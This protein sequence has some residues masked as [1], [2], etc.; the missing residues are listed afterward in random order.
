MTNLFQLSWKQ[1][2]FKPLS[3]LMNIILFA[4]G[5]GIVSLLLLISTEIEEK[6]DKNQAG[7]GMV[8][9]AKGSPLQLILCAIFHID[10]PTGNIKLK[11]TA[12]LKKHP[13]V[14]QII[15]QALGDSYQ[16]FRIVGTNH[17]YA[18][19]Y[20]A[21]L[22]EGTLWEKD[23]EVTIGSDVAQK[24]GL[25]VGS[26]FAGSHGMVES[27]DSHEHTLLK[28]TGILSHTG[29]V[30]DQ[31]ILTNIESVWEV[32]E[33]HEE[34]EKDSLAHEKNEEHHHH[35]EAENEESHV[36]EIEEDR[37]IT[38]LL[39]KFRSPLGAIQLPRFINEKTNLQAATPAFE[40]SR[41]FSLMGVGIDTL[42]GLAYLIMLVSGLSVFISLFS[43]LK[44][45]KYE[46]AYMRVIGAKKHQLFGMILLEGILLAFLGY[47][48]GIILSHF[49]LWFL[50][51]N[52]E[53]AFH[54]SFAY[55]KFLIEEFYLLVGSLILGIL[56]SLIPAY[57]AFKT[58]IS[59]TLAEN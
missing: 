14:A 16:T 52:M 4:L 48:V 35:E 10:F 31:L 24:T 21:T 33:H 25:K 36:K 49:T 41:L 46:L 44:E 38:T 59:K 57:Q 40:I 42:N 2:S 50:S 8:V 3:T 29:T 17:D 5:V 18:K 30:I 39:V 20:N 54:Q 11:D 23:M 58:D 19:L 27:D 34:E 51:E 53:D 47:V 32:H 9:G 15:P 37:E 7:I 26:T 12:F 45:R 13:L 6:L 43:S 1:L 28:V 55:Q 56:A 22:Q